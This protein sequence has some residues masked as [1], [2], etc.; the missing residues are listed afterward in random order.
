M[1]T[2]DCGMGSKFEAMSTE[3]LVAVLRGKTVDVLPKGWRED[4]DRK[5]PECGM[6]AQRQ[7]CAFDLGGGCPRH[8]PDAYDERQWI[9]IP[10]PLSSA[11]ADAIERL[12]SVVPA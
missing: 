12:S 8:D 7:K 10:D 6:G 5:C 4:P 9:T 1:Q 2:E 3:E 11:A